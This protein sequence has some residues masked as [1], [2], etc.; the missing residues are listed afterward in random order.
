MLESANYNIIAR[1]NTDNLFIEV[2]LLKN[3]YNE[4]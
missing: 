2:I 3:I 1:K 4:M